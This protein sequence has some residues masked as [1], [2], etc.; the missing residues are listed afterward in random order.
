MA[1]AVLGYAALRGTHALDGGR[2]VLVGAAMGL[3]AA[4]LAIA[5]GFV[6]YASP[7]PGAGVPRGARPVLGVVVPLSMLAPVAFLLC[8]AVRR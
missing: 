8:L 2:G 1:G 4:L 3:L 7:R 5:V 6:E